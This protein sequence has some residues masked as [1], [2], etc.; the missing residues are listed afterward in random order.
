MKFVPADV[1]GKDG[2]DLL[3]GTRCQVKLLP[4]IVQ[5]E[6]SIEDLIV[7]KCMP[8]KSYMLHI[9]VHCYR[10]V[11]VFIFIGEVKAAR[12]HIHKLFLLP[13]S[14]LVGFLNCWW[15]HC[16]YVIFHGNPMMIGISK[17][18]AQIYQ[19]WRVLGNVWAYRAWKVWQNH[20]V[21][22]FKS[23]SKASS[24]SVIGDWTP[25]RLF[26]CIAKHF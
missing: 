6:F 18:N 13:Q 23:C 10:Y 26:M 24:P 14:L 11:T 7:P 1:W 25:Y 21:I 15:D 2:V 12:T 5:E 20:H 3:V 19:Y 16:I 17:L 8:L 22:C 9:P 4:A